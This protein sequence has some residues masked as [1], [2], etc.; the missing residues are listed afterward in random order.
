MPVMWCIV[1]EKGHGRQR[2]KLYEDTF[3]KILLIAIVHLPE[4]L[5][6]F[7]G[8]KEQKK[9]KITTKY[10]INADEAKEMVFRQSYQHASVFIDVTR[11]VHQ[12][13]RW[14]FRWK[15]VSCDRF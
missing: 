1:F 11:N 14:N 12:C 7:V 5:Y 15:T 4:D 8:I 6:T 9:F 13:S 10:A 3:L 2:Q